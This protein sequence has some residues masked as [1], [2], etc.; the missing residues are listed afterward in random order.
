MSDGGDALAR[1]RKQHAEL[2]KERTLDLRIPGWNGLLIARYSPVRAGEMRKLSNRINKL[3]GQENAE[4]DLAAAADLIIT[5][6][7]EI[8]TVVDGEKIPLATEAGSDSPVGYDSRLA[9][10]VGFEAESARD[11]VY[12]VFPQFEDGAVIETTVNAHALEV[13]EWITNVD[14][15]VADVF[16]GES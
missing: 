6:C 10:I 13:A 8:L 3:A 12:G 14:E 15:E 11:V 4:A 9:E 1:L 5:A 2:R 7:R 16:A